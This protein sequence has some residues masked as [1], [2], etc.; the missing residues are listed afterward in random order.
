MELLQ[1]IANISGKPGLYRIVKPGR[2][3]V[4]VESLDDVKKREMV[5]ANAK[6]SVLKEISIYSEDYNKS[7]PLSDIFFKIRELHGEKVEIDVKTVSNKDVFSFFEKIMPDYDREKVY[8][9]DVKKIIQWYNLLSKN[10]PE[11]F[12]VK[13]ASEEA[14]AEK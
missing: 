4:I 14:E 3:G 1:E 7:T 9:T 2:T 5:N 6:V 10:L 8:H 12:E 13:A 11:I